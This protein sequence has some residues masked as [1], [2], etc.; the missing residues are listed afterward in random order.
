MAISE[1]DLRQV[2]RFVRLAADSPGADLFTRPMLRELGSLFSADLV[3]Y[4]EIREPDRIGIAY[5]ASDEQ[6]ASPSID[7]A[8]ERFRHQ[9]PLGAFRWTVAA[10]ALRLSTV[11]SRQQ[12]RHLEFHDQVLAPLHIRDQLKV[13]LRRSS[14]SAVC[15]S[16]DRSE[17]SFSERDVALLDVLQPHLRLL[18][19]ARGVA[20]SRPMRREA[21][22]TRREAQVLTSALAGLG[23]REIGELLV[24]SPHTVRKHL[25]HAYL[26]L[27][28]RGRVAAAAV[29]SSSPRR[30]PP[31]APD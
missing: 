19:D 5:E 2:M 30:Q 13:W 8:F 4:F 29:L 28:V 11:I 25:E 26:K 10:G 9:N 31:A 23:N 1:R 17:G 18:H 22:L 27:G 12:L 16:M 15:L 6:V 7:E 21:H 14:A 20:S 3:E 24:I